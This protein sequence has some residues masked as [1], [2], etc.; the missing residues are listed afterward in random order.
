LRSGPNTS[1]VRAD[2]RPSVQRFRIPAT[3][4]RFGSQTTTVPPLT[5]GAG[6]RSR[7]R[8]RRRHGPI[9]RRNHEQANDHL[10]GAPDDL[11]DDASDEEASPMAELGMDGSHRMITG[12]CKAGESAIAC[13][14]SAPT[15]VVQAVEPPVSQAG[16]PGA[17][18]IFARLELLPSWSLK[19]PWSKSGPP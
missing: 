16:D 7:R 19:R 17:Q 18:T 4:A 1:G 15:R 13:E 10:V 2:G 3:D 14:L 8:S 11:P 5:D 12:P 9:G 6:R